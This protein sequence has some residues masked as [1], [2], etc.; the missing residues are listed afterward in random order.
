M[1]IPIAVVSSLVVLVVL[2]AIV[3]FKI[4]QQSETMVIERLGRYN[5]TLDSG[6]NIIWPV[7]DRPRSIQWNYVHALPDG[8]NIVRKQTVTRIDLRETVYDFPR[9]NV[10]TRDNVAIEINALLYFQI[11]DSK[12]AIY[13]I[14]NLPDAIE[15]LTQTTLRNVIGELD[16]DHTLTSRDTINQKLKAILDEAT[17][18]W[19]VKVNR[20]ELQDIIPPQDIKVAM[21]KQMRAERDRRAMILEAEGLKQSK[22]LEAEGYRQAEITRADGQRQA[23]VLTANGEA[24]ARIKV[25]EAEAEAVARVTK[26]IQA[27]GGN[28]TNYLLAV[29]YIE[30]LKEMVSGKDNKVVYLPYEASALLGSVGGIRDMFAGAPQPVPGGRLA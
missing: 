8:K 30:T 3:G 4:I 7:I 29:R 16:L 17:D 2:F 27:S 18:K 12:R 20:I 21:E 14:A 1:E 23:L 9:Q 25:A 13:E 26:A 5:R 19:G 11:S 24:E 28:P 15:K 6:I 22:I 10:I